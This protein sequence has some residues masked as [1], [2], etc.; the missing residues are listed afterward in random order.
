ME[1][2]TATDARTE[3]KRFTESVDITE[4]VEGD[5]IDPTLVARTEGQLGQTTKPA[6]PEGDQPPKT[7]LVTASALNGMDDTHSAVLVDGE[8]GVMV[9]AHR[10]DGNQAWSQKEA[11]W[12]VSDVGTKVIVDSVHELTLADSDDPVDDDAE[13][14][15]EWANIVLGDIASGYF[16]YAD[17]VKMSGS[18]LTLSDYDGRKGQATISLE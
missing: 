15:E 10:H 14:T 5:R 1:N 17:G 12:K 6:H 4:L 2:Q 11:D 3:T 16:D 7:Q 8:S 9:R 13:Y 18:T